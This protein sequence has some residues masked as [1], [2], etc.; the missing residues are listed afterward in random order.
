LRPKAGRLRTR[1]DPTNAERQRRFKERRKQR[2]LATVT[3]PPPAAVTEE[4]PPVVTDPGNA[5]AAMDRPTVTPPT[6]A[7]RN[8]VTVAHPTDRAADA[9][10]SAASVA[11]AE[12]ATPRIEVLPP[13][14]RSWS[15]IGRAGVGLAIVATGA[16][17]AYTSMRGNSWFGH[18]LTPDQTA[19]DIYSQLSVAAEVLACL[20]PTGIRFYAQDGE[21]WTALRGWALMLVTLAVVFLAAGGF[22]ITNLNS[23]IEARAERQTSEVVLAQRKL[24]TLAKA[25]EA[26]CK[27]RGPECRRLEREEQDAI[28]ALGRAQAGVRADADPQ[29]A[30]LGISSTHL[31]LVQAG[32]MVALCLFSGLF[33]SFGAGLIWP[34]S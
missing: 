30:A 31:H 6:V 16:W 24:D 1:P 12:P 20:I 21:R 14:Y 34:R 5:G 9:A 26:E 29:A 15:A 27:R 11:L 25:R 22:A 17:I 2:Q 18:S 8:G 23:G 7:R 13:R 19:G 3:E 32:A 28:V 4:P 10:R 33:I